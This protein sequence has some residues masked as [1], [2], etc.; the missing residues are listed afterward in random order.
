M[1]GRYHFYRLHP[2]SYVELH[3]ST[4]T[5]P[6]PAEEL[7]FSEKISHS[8]FEAL[9]HYGGFPEALFKQNERFLRRWHN[10][11]LERFFKG[12]IRELTLIQDFGSLSLLADLLP[13]KTSSIL[14]INSLARYLGVNFRTVARW[15]DTFELFYYCFRVPPFQSKKVA[16]VKKEKNFPSMT[17]RR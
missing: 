7:I 12:D 11:R 8:D 3:S 10:E 13:E 16:S 6:E 17:G 2:F 5:L 15:L 1:Q 14:S 4:K 9:F